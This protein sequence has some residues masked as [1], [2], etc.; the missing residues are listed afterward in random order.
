MEPSHS[1]TEDTVNTGV[2]NSQL[3][4][5]LQTYP[6]QADFEFKKGLSIILG[7]PDRPATDSE[8]NSE[9]DLVLQAKCFYFSRKAKLMSPLAFSSYKAWLK[10]ERE[11]ESFLTGGA[12]VEERKESDAED[13]TGQPFPSDPTVSSDHNSEKGEQP[14]EPV[15]PSSFAHIVELITTGQPIPGIQQ[16]PDTVLTG[17]DTS[18]A[19]PRRKKPWE[20]AD[21]T[22]LEKEATETRNIQPV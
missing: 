14:K 10:S 5:D 19:K 7:H 18:S 9:D 13:T 20:K 2:Q 11:S 1:S 17:H 8:I 12:N 21:S 16:I 3:F 22:T 4:S 6:F 15:Y